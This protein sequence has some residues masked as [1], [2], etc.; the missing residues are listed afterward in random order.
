MFKGNGNMGH[1]WQFQNHQQ[2]QQQ[3][4]QQLYPQYQNYQPLQ[5]PQ[6]MSHLVSHGGGGGSLRANQIYDGSSLS[7]MSLQAA[8]SSSSTLFPLS[9]ATHSPSFQHIYGSVSNAPFTSLQSSA[10]FI[11]GAG[12]P[13]P[14]PQSMFK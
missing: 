2:Q 7:A 9:S 14:Q 12:N 1:G 5:Q 3:Q 4:Q 13:S 8:P 10:S 6:G 11:Y